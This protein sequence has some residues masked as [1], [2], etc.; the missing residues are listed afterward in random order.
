[1]SNNTT[2][3]SQAALP[4]IVDNPPVT[5]LTPQPRNLLAGIWNHSLRITKNNFVNKSLSMWA[6]NLAIGCTHGCRFCYVP[7]TSTGFL[8]PK[9]A[10]R[11]VGDPDSDWGD[12][13]FLR[14][15]DEDE[16]LA[17]LRTAE[18]TPAKNLNRDGNRA[19]MFCTTTDP[20]QAFTGPNAADLNNRQ[21]R[22]LRRALELIRDQST[23]NVRILTRSPLVRRDFELLRTL[24]N[25]VMVGASIPTLDNTLARIYEPHAPAPT[26]R[27]ETLQAAKEAGLN[28]FAAL[29]P[30]YPE[31]DAAD[32]R[33]TMTALAQIEPATLFMEPIN[34]RAENVERIAAHAREVGRELNVGVFATREAW[35]SY[36]LDQLRLVHRLA[37][38]LGLADRLHLWPDGGLEPRSTF[39]RL[40]R[41]RFV[42]V[43]GNARLTGAARAIRNA[44]D[45]AAYQ[46]HVGWLRNW[47]NRISEWPGTA[48]PA[49]WI[50][51][52]LPV[53]PL[54]PPTAEELN[55]QH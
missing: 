32:L 46:Q 12:Y 13:A 37:G 1:M 53:E 41:E 45:E 50:T 21:A 26:K 25:R 24:G 36:S 54:N 30:T 44:A 16:F 51:P 3:A 52:Q 49:P 34:I 48:N 15:W 18:N 19:V 11:G 31:C 47:W 9:L 22:M 2:A 7:D 38:E 40:R 23:L 29:A 33:R 27:L 17:S 39:M 28:V 6:C 55:A 42:A 10:Q 8:A 5:T 43:H 35:F 14:P 4:S 20:Y